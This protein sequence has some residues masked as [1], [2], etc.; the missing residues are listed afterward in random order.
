MLK[1][2]QEVAELKPEQ[3][4]EADCQRQPYRKRSLIVAQDRGDR[5]WKGKILS[6]RVKK[7]QAF[8]MRYLMVRLRLYQEA[9]IC[10]IQK[11]LEFLA[12]Q[13]TEITEVRTKSSVVGQQRLYFSEFS[14]IKKH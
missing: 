9:D 6:K 13:E 8:M 1:I 4:S 11:S 2:E 5:L 3:R 7:E 12:H 14:G 10:R